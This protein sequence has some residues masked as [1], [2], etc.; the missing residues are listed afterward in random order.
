MSNGLTDADFTDLSLKEQDAFSL[1]EAAIRLDQ[2]RNDKEMLAAA[3][4]RNMEIWVAIR[5]LV[6]RA[7]EGVQAETRD[8]LVRL[9]QFVAEKTMQHGVDIPASVLDTLIN[10][11]LQIAEGLLEGSKD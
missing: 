5:T 9:S 8:N 1:S 10:V 7:G 2:S 4:E 6:S 11:N 3:L